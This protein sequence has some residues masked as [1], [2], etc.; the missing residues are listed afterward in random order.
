MIR[1]ISFILSL[2][3]LLLV[4]GNLFSQT[5][6]SGTYT[7]AEF[8]A[9]VKNNSITLTDNVTVSSTI[10]ITKGMSLTIDLAGF[11]LAGNMTSESSEYVISVADGGSL[12]I[13]DSNPNVGHAAHLDEKGVMVWGTSGQT[14]AISG[15]I[16][17]NVQ[18]GTS[19]DTKGISV[20]GVCV[21]E[22]AKIMGCYS[23]SFGAAVTVTSSG[24]F[25]MKA[26]EIR[27][28]YS[29]SN[30]IVS[31][32]TDGNRAGVV[33]GEPSHN[34]SGSLLNLSNTIISDNNTTGN[35]GAI[36]GYKVILNNC[37]IERNSTTLNGGAIYMR[38]AADS[39]T[40][41]SLSVVSCRINDNKAGY[42]GGA[43]YT[44][45]GVSTSISGSSVISGNEAVNAGGG[46]YATDLSIVGTQAEPVRVE[47]NVSVSGG[48]IYVTEQCDI[49]YCNISS[50]LAYANG[51]GILSH[52]APTSIR[53]SKIN[54]NYAM[55]SEEK[56]QE[57]ITNYGRGGGFYFQG[58]ADRL[59]AG[60]EFVLRD[61]EVNGN[62][63]MYYGGGGQV[64]SGA[65]LKM[66]EGTEINSNT[67]ILHGAGG[68]HVT[69]AAHLV[70]NAGEISGNT[71]HSVG[72]GIHSSYECKLDLNGGSISNNTVLGRGAG[73]H[74][75]TGGDVVLSG[76]DIIG[77]KAKIGYDYRYSTVIGSNGN[78]SWTPPASDTDEPIDRTGYGGGVLID[79]GTCVMQTGNLTGNYAEVG[80]GGIALV[81]IN[82]PKDQKFK[83]IKVVEFTLNNG[84]LGQ[85][86][87]DGNGA[88]VF[89]MKNMCRDAYDKLSAAEK[90]KVGEVMTQ[91]E[92]Q[93]LF[94]GVPKIV[95][96]AGSLI[97][98][99]AKANGGGSYQEENTR[100]VINGN[101][102]SLSE[103]VA[104]KSGGAAY[105]ALGTVEIYG[106]TIN[107]NKAT[108]NG[109]ALYVNGNV[110]MT[111]GLL[112][113]NSA[114]NGGGICILNGKVNITKGNVTDNEATNY[115]GGLYVANE[116]A[117][118]NI[119]MA[120]EGVFNGNT[121]KAGGGMA[122]GGPIQLNFEGSIQNN[123]A[124]NGGGIYLLPKKSTETVGATLNL[125]DGFIRN[126]SAEA[127][128][129]GVATG[130]HGSVENLKGFGGGVFMG[131]GTTF[132]TD[133]EDDDYFGFYGNVA[134]VGG[135]D[136]FANGNGTTVLLPDVEN[137][138]L[139]DY[140]VP[141][142][143]LY[144]VEDYVTGDTQYSVGSNVITTAGYTPV[145]YQDALRAGSV[146]IGR[147]LKEDYDENKDKY[148]CISLGYELYYVVLQKLGLE[149]GDTAIFNVS[150]VNKNGERVDYRKALFIGKGKDTPVNV[151]VAL[152]PNTWT[153]T[154]DSKW[155]WKYKSLSPLTKTIS[156]RADVEEPIVFE[157][158]LKDIHTDGESSKVHDETAKENRMKL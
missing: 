52:R 36:I 13:K 144:W 3:L 88:G 104:N 4:P 22:R 12:T 45:S 39:A 74:V 65:V 68:L 86:T 90:T 100:F 113:N 34:N 11:V 109:G 56:G 16:I 148:L 80:G 155:S 98:N 126:N 62:A 75:N 114:Y 44:E 5:I 97:G 54:G 107:S 41:G 118:T 14:M 146:D 94:D 147:I 42:R 25:T 132:K 157:N 7:G 66:N 103:N 10:N 32:E 117:G 53:D 76:T 81:M 96:N 130:H 121:A 134:S 59:D 51:G 156:S 128:T 48:G 140:D 145:R 20:S 71:A 23:K 55:S 79:S 64:C 153:F 73:V 15:G 60:P 38:R 31:G 46:I 119:T 9:K 85:N 120:G 33:Y 43:I 101:S 92:L 70:L 69:S 110:T 57:K 18:K 154:E 37:T 143:K 35:C 82:M 83:Q 106:G 123:V 28:N 2:A 50:N 29:A 49:R 124:E 133:I 116:T 61:T 137:M 95:I 1:C 27:Y 115:G 122:V 138:V 78:Y 17:Y 40:D 127:V 102:A 149:S 141:T 84:L 151:T 139:S 58:T 77:N 112:K 63:A 129:S 142:S 72:G 111:A 125:S 6:G 152:P 136:I 158:V 105:I 30:A 93:A 26:G 89:L 91:A 135:S 8:L 67:A 131:D 24:S 99:V 19:R 47:K 150:Y 87:T 21:V 108:E